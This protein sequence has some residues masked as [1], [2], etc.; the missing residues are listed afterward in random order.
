MKILIGSSKEALLLARL[1]EI[2][3]LGAAEELRP[4]R[5][6][7]VVH[8]QRVPEMAV[9]DHHRAIVRERCNAGV[10]PVAVGRARTDGAAMIML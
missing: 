10:L 4:H 2:A 9:E 1:A 6:E 8:G 3:A 5:I 7:A